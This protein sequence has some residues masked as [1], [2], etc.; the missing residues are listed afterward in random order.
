MKISKKITKLITISSLFLVF[1]ACAKKEETN[2]EV[3]KKKR[4]NPNVLE[5]AGEARDKGG[6]IFNSSRNN[7]SNTFEFSTSNVLWRASLD[8]LEFI[9]LNN[10]DYSGGVIV[11]D[12]YSKDSGLE[13]IKFTIRFLS[14]ELSATSL[15]VISYKK[16]CD[17][18]KLE[19]NVSAG[20][21]KLSSEIK[22]SI[23]NKARKI[24]LEDEAKKKK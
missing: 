22:N 6:G 1:Y 14:N 17:Q 5:R 20:S 15:K 19:C 3:I 10:V 4:I 7:T 12:W 9:P 24:S 23:L 13:S 18:S 16:I 21:S 8:V 2:Q 11:T